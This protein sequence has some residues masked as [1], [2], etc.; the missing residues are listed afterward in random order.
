[1]GDG[2]IITALSPLGPGNDLDARFADGTTRAR[3]ARPPRP[4]LGPGAPGAQ[5]G[6]WQEGLA[7]S[8]KEPVRQDAVIRSFSLAKAK[9]GAVADRPRAR[10][11][12]SS[13]ATTAH[14][15][16]HR[17][18]LARLPAGSR[19][20]HHRRGGPRRRRARQR[21]R[22]GRQP[23][24]HAGRLRRADRGSIKYFL[25]NGAV[26]GGRA[27][28]VAGGIQGV[29]R[30]AGWPRACAWSRRPPREPRGRGGVIKGG[31]KAESDVIL[32]VDSTPVTSPEALAEAIRAH[33]MGEKVPITV[34][35][36]GKYREVTVVLRAGPEAKAAPPPPANPAELPSA[37][38]PPAPAPPPAGA[39]A[40]AAAHPSLNVPPRPG[41]VAPPG[42]APT[43]RPWSDARRLAGRV[44]LPVDT[45]RAKTRGFADVGVGPA[46][47]PLFC[48]VLR[49]IRGPAAPHR[50]CR[51]D[52]RR[53]EAQ[54]TT[55]TTSRSS[56]RAASTSSRTAWAVTPRAKSR[57]R[58]RSTP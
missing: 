1:M 37:N 11:A 20:A 36:Q 46:R 48:S 56:R 14:R 10:T 28:G 23:A 52:E 26:D 44:R 57:A 45:S 42:P 5:S 50:G 27:G 29:A 34:F 54:R 16:R 9:I 25:R 8:T 21:V 32:A 49:V 13:A 12:R 17:D 51:R 47:S 7:A 58:W 33:G 30:R 24:L 4:R 53:H 19:L 2:R 43:G 15:Q 39:Q 6:R 41:N 22:A 40:P 38:E 31:D 35:G 18:R 55:R 3:Q